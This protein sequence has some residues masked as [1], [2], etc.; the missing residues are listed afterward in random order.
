MI[1]RFLF[2]MCSVVQSNFQIRHGCAMRHV[3]IAFAGL[4]VAWQAGAQPAHQGKKKKARSDFP[5][6]TELQPHEAAKL[7]REDSVLRLTITANFSRLEHDRSGKS[8]WRQARIAYTNDSGTI[9]DLPVRLRTRGIWRLKECDLPP[10]RMNFVKDSVKHTIFAKLDKPKLVTH[11]RDNKTGDQ[12]IVAEF[13]LYRAYNL[14]TPY[15][16]RVRLAQVVYA[17]SGN[18][19]VETTRYAF[20]EEEP[21]A[22]ADRVGGILI[23]QQGA[24]ANDLVPSATTLFYM[25]QYFIGNTDWSIAALHNVELIT[26]DT[27]HVPI[28]YDFDFSGAVNA[29][30]ATV[31]PRLSIRRVRDRL[32]RGYCQPDELFPP[33]FEVFRAKRDSIYAL[34]HD[35]IGRLL[36]A[37]RAK[38]TLEYFDDLYKTINDPRE[39]AKQIRDNCLRR[40]P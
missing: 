15:S 18:G 4:V 34:Y 39:A 23:Q 25:F 16:H 27:L 19:K 32:Y 14:L 31:D 11:C 12:L 8:P 3:L 38:E 26:S 20:L 29:P 9:V 36:D 5:A 17:D 22:V 13:Q 33:V 1:S 35:P 30:Y 10:F 37:D 28:P 7:F 6:Q 21:E 24:T 40:G 2:S